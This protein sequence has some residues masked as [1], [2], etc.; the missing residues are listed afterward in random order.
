LHEIYYKLSTWEIKFHDSDRVIETIL[1]IMER[2]GWEAF[3][4]RN[5]VELGSELSYH[6]VRFDGP[7]Q[8]VSGVVR[9]LAKG[10]RDRNW[11]VRE[12]P[13]VEPK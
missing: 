4:D 1:Q 10:F 6:D 9:V 11:K 3:P 5:E 2:L 12:Q 8:I 13:L 7:K